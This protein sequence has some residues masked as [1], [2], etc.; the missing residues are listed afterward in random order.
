MALPECEVAPSHLTIVELRA[1]WCED[2]GPEWTSL[3]IARLRYTASEKTW[4]LFWCDRNLRFHATT[5]CPRRRASTICSP[6]ST[7]IAV[8]LLPMSCWPWGSPRLWGESSCLR[9]A[10]VGQR[11]STSSLRS[12][13]LAPTG[14]PGGSLSC[15]P[16]HPG[17]ARRCGSTST[18]T[19]TSSGSSEGQASSGGTADGVLVA[20]LASDHRHPRQPGD[21]PLPAVGVPHRRRRLPLSALTSRTVPCDR[22]WPD[23]PDDR[24]SFAMT[25]PARTRLLDR[26]CARLGGWCD[27]LRRAHAARIP[28]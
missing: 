25:P 26:I 17:S 6:R 11:N 21:L 19:A 16:D 5:P 20:H 10:R 1:P 28:F 18:R 14:S 23:V 22:P 8:G 2:F 12:C 4:T 24:R 27:V 7:A 13:I 3:P 9:A 15:G